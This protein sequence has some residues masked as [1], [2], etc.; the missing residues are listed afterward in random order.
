MKSGMFSKN[1]DPVLDVFNLYDI[2]IKKILAIK[3]IGL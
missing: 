3:I 1:E 2:M